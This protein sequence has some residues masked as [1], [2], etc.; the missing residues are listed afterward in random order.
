MKPT[1]EEM[2]AVLA[3]ARRRSKHR[4]ESAGFQT[5]SLRDATSLRYD[6]RGVSIYRPT[7]A[8]QAAAR[9][10]H[11]HCRA[12]SDGLLLL[13]DMMAAPDGHLD[14]PLGSL[15]LMDAVRAVRGIGPARADE[16]VDRSMPHP[17]SGDRRVR[18]LTE[19][20]RRLGGAC[21][22]PPR[23]GLARGPRGM[24]ALIKAA[25]HEAEAIAREALG[26]GD[27]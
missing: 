19:R 3:F 5:V 9:A 15:R 22:A 8:E 21:A 24:S 25:K 13:A 16:I 2:A 1:A 20:E 18:D 23:R 17:P 6:S 27:D 7:P 26:G 4:R 10:W 11:D 12:V 14:G